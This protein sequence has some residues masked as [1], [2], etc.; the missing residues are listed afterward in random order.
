MPASFNEKNSAI[1]SG[2]DGASTLTGCYFFCLSKRSNQEK[3]TEIETHWLGQL[4]HKPEISTGVNTPIERHS[5]I[6][7]NLNTRDNAAYP[8]RHRFPGPGSM[9]AQSFIFS[10]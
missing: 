4:T 2:N 7:R 1:R 6:G 10:P 5:T 9:I 3:E 8:H